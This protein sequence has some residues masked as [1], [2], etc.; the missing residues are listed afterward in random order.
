M[1][2]DFILKNNLYKILRTCEWELASSTD[3]IVTDL[4][5]EDGFMHL[6]TAAQL[7]GTLSFYFK[8]SDSVFLHL[9]ANFAAKKGNILWQASNKDYM[10][11]GIEELTSKGLDEVQTWPISSRPLGEARNIYD[12]GGQFI[13]LLGSN[14]LFHHPE[15]R[16]PE[17]IDMAKLEKL[18]SFMMKMITDSANSKA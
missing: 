18:N 4:D 1:K 5:T 3:Q 2:E 9:G 12:G 13:S 16:W 8:E 17:A 6:S 10:N 7:A 14:S 15:D 11:I